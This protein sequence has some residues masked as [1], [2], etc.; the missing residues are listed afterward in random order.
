MAARVVTVLAIMMLLC[1]ASVGCGEHPTAKWMN[2]SSGPSP[3]A[4]ANPPGVSGYLATDAASVTFLQWQTDSSGNLAGTVYSAALSGSPPAES[5]EV[6]NA[7]ISGTIN[8]STLTLIVNGKTD[9]GTFHGNGSL[10]LNVEQPDGS[11]R[12]VAYRQASVSDYNTSLT[13]LKNSADSANGAEAQA[14]ASASQAQAQAEASASAASAA[15]AAAVLQREQ[16]E[17]QNVGGT[18]ENGGCGLSYRDHDGIESG[19]SVMFD[20]SG[21]I[22]PEY[23]GPQNS[24]ECQTYYKDATPYVGKWHPDSKICQMY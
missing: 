7:A 24:T 8:K 4:P 21:D 14:E 9:Y 23:G 3:M 5:V 22:I 2:P 6:D 15:A 18:W 10:V 12:A 20:E 1:G 19:Y 13:Q 11:I 16:T 17:C